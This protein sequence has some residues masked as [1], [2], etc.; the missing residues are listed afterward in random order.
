MLIQSL[1]EEALPSVSASAQL[2]ANCPATA[3]AA[4]VT[5]RSSSDAC[6][7]IT[8]RRNGTATAGANGVDIPLG[9]RVIPLDYTNALLMRAIE[10]GGTVTGYIQYISAAADIIAALALSSE[11]KDRTSQIEDAVVDLTKKDR[12]SYTVSESGQVFA[13]SRR[14][15]RATVRVSSSGV[16]KIR[17]GGS[18]GTIV[19]GESSGGAVT[20]GGEIMFDEEVFASG[21]YMQIVSGTCTLRFVAEPSA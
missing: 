13:D 21:L 1:L 15:T 14:V 2:F 7:G 11:A 8:L 9:T 19:W 4:I 12:A 10:N 16:V 20:T 18:S 17:S 3:N 6:K 5:L